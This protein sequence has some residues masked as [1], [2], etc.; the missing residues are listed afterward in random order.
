[1]NVGPGSAN[2][3]NR[4]QGAAEV[5][6]LPGRRGAADG[7]ALVQDHVPARR[8]VEDRQP[9]GV[10]VDVLLHRL[11]EFELVAAVAGHQR[12]AAEQVAFD[13][14][15]WRVRGIAAAFRHRVEVAEGGTAQDVGDERELGA[16]PGEEDRAACELALG[17]FDHVVF[18]GRKVEFGLGHPVAPV[19]GDEVRLVVAAETD[20]DR[21]EA[22][23]RTGVRVH[24]IDH[25]PAAAGTHLG[26]RA[27][28]GAVGAH[29]LGLAAT[30][31]GEG[32]ERVAARAGRDDGNVVRHR[33]QGG[34][35]ARLEPQARRRGQIGDRDA[36][37]NA[38]H[39][40]GHDRQAVFARNQEIGSLIA[41]EVGTLE[42]RGVVRKVQRD[43]G[44]R[45]T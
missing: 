24:G 30:G 35:G 25:R 41:V 27:D 22:L 28:A 1:M 2:D 3:S 23:T 12:V 43:R 26:Q 9:G 17:F 18:G 32:K 20:K 15:R 45:P 40:R 44:G 8:Q 14:P 4:A 33:D 7:E 21:G 38:A 11:P 37:Q 34:T 31:E 6:R 42:D 16:V 10:Q 19:E 36:R 13:G 5:D 39:V 29:L